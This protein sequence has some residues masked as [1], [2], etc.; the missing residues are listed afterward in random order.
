MSKTLY[1]V[2]GGLAGGAVA[3]IGLACLAAI[4][5]V[6]LASK[7]KESKP[8]A[9]QV[10]QEPVKQVEPF[11]EQEPAKQVQKPKEQ[12]PG[13]SKPNPTVRRYDK[14]KDT[15]GLSAADKDTLA[16]LYAR[17]ER[18]VRNLYFNEYS[19]RVKDKQLTPTEAADEMAERLEA[20]RLKKLVPTHPVFPY[21][22]T[23]RGEYYTHPWKCGFLDYVDSVRKKG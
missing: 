22:G 1:W 14:A 11:K 17:G 13:E 18:D 4:V 2:I 23:G 19:R 20:I 10:G 3:L 12:E 6:A 7:E 8:I 15:E 9:K 21:E 16:G 5:W